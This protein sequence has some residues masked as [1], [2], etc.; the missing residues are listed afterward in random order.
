MKRII[1]LLTL[2]ASTSLGYC[3]EEL[4]NVIGDGRQTVTTAGTEVQLSS[5]SIPCA[6]VVITAETDNTNA[7]V[8]GGDSV[9]AALA[10]RRGIP[11]FAGDSIVV[12]TNNLNKIWIDAITDTEGVTYIYYL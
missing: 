6:R 1:V 11:L 12:K 3:G 5:S 2:L 7:V 10:T 9:I 4:Y 8:V